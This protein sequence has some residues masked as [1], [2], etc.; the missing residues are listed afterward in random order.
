MYLSRQEVADY[1][2]VSES[3]VRKTI[4]SGKTQL[5]RHLKCSDR[6]PKKGDPAPVRIAARDLALFALTHTRSGWESQREED[7]LADEEVEAKVREV[8]EWVAW[9][10]ERLAKTRPDEP[11]A[12]VPGLAHGVGNGAKDARP[13]RADK[14]PL[15]Y[16]PLK[17]LTKAARSSASYLRKY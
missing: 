15:P 14:P 7:E 17:K 3:F 2:A 12:E 8:W 6:P 13:K 1:L 9:H 10:R 4:E 16:T 11:V 5:S